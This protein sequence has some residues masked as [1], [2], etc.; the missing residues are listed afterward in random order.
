MHLVS[1]S[2]LNWGRKKTSPGSQ[3]GDEGSGPDG[4]VVIWI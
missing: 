1:G 2:K 3:L 4:A